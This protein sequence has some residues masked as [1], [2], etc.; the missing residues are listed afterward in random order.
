MQGSFTMGDNAAVSG[1]TAVTS[2]NGG[3]GGGVDV[4]QGSFTKTGGVI[5]GRNET[6][7]TLRN[8]AKNSDGVEQ[9]YRGAAVFTRYGNCRETTVGTAQNLAVSYNNDQGAYTYTGQWMDDDNYTTFIAVTNIT[10]VLTGVI[11]GIDKILGGTAQ[12]GYAT[13]QTITWSV[14]SAGTTGAS[15]VSGNTLRTTS[16]GTAT[17]RATITN[18]LTETSDFTKDFAITVVAVPPFPANGTLAERLG[19]LSNYAADGGDYTIELSADEA[20]NETTLSY[21]SKTVKITLIGA[22]TERTV[23]QSSNGSMFTVGSGVTLTLGN[24]VT[25]QG[26]NVVAASPVSVNSGATLAMKGN[27]KI[28]GGKASSGGGVYV[29]GGSFTM[30]DNATVSGNTAYS[31]G[32]G[33]Y[34][35]SGSFTMSGNAT[36]SGNNTTAYPGASSGGG[37]YV[38]G[39]SFTMSG[40]ATVSGNN[41]ASYPGGGGVYVNGGSFTMSD[42]ATVSGNTA[43]SS[44]GGVYVGGGSFTMSDNAAVSGNMTSSTYSGGGVYVGSGSFTMSDNAAISGNT[45]TARSGDTSYGGGVYVA[46]GNFTKTG[47]IIYGSD[48]T[49]ATLR[50]VIKNSEGVVQYRWGAAVYANSSYRCETT[51]G[52]VRNLSVVYDGSQRTYTGQWDDITAPTLSA[53]SVEALTTTAGTTATLNFTSNRAGTYYYLGLAST[54]DTP[55]AA[56]IQAQGTAVVK[57]SAAASAGQNTVSV[58]GLTADTLYK[59]YI[60]VKDAAWNVSDVL[61]ISGVNPAKLTLSAGSVE[62][63]KTTVGTTATLKF[64][65]NEAG[66]YYYLVLPAS[67]GAPTAATIQAQGTA[68]AKGSAAASAGQ[69]S[70][71]VTGLTAGTQYRA[72]IVVYDAAGNVSNVLAISGVN[73]TIFIPVTNI[74]GVPTNATAGTD[75]TL[76]GT[77]AP[78]NATVKTIAWSVYSAGTTR[79]SIVSG[80]LRTMAAGTVTV[81]ATITNG[82][83]TSSYKQDFTIA[84]VASASAGNVTVTTL[85][86]GTTSGHADGTGTAAS[87]GGVP[88]NVAVDTAGNVYVADQHNS[89]IRKISSAGEVTTL[90]DGIVTMNFVWPTGVAVDAYDNVYFTDGNDSQSIWIIPTGSAAVRVAGG[91]IGSGEETRFQSLSGLAVD[92]AGNVYVANGNRIRKVSPIGVVTTL[93]G[94]TEGYADGTGTAARFFWPDGVA[95]DTA[96]NVYVADSMNNRIRKISPTGVVTTLAGDGTEGY[97]DGTGLAARFYRPEGVAVDTADNVYV[98]D[99]GNRIRKISPAGVVTTLAGDGTNG[100]ADGTGTEA[101]FGA[102]YGVAVDTAGNVYVFDGFTIRKIT[103]N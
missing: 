101:K 76:S 49:E 45:A 65:A 12:P 44:G 43:Y 87:F 103:Q 86:G 91:G 97:A 38:S 100:Y 64:T 80:K 55:T 37:V 95:V 77:V 16:T 9:T 81:Q 11:V 5:Y 41:T 56:T 18:G 90:V 88:G 21:N 26:R 40:N 29:N 36:V 13:N 1:N 28:T 58:T 84:V 75:L 83:A 79:A 22:T 67:D 15:I 57:G 74:T 53:G 17:V 63:L 2:S 39:G 92:I 46:S 50:N 7:A 20:I 33:V 10:D 68:V 14:H 61:T 42:N 3:G 93:A 85:A 25:L 70:I 60:V 96:G 47:G 98:V 66:T 34:V 52:T 89:R 31:S 69:N 8:I 51:V 59:A 54:A 24:N 30:S 23:S 82:L 78:T 73:P 62:A 35:S 71:S 94:S 102:L 6:D 27:A 4:W 32:G 19:W 72:Y 48:E 99:G